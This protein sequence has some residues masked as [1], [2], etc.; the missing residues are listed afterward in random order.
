MKTNSFI[1]NTECCKIC[2]SI[3]NKIFAAQILN[4]YMVSY[5][6][7]GRCGFIQ[8]E[9]PFWLEE[10]YANS[11]NLSDTGLV[12]GNIKMSRV[13]RLLLMIRFSAR[14]SYLDYGGGFGLFTRLMRDSGYDFIHRIY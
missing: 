13:V 4:R 14:K 2:D 3:S 12:S 1:K 9:N 11:I 8:T 6:K 5:Y 10:A 7:C